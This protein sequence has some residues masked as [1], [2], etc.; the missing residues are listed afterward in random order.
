MIKHNRHH[1]PSLRALY[2]R[3][4]P[5]NL[6]CL[7]SGIMS[8]SAC[9]WLPGNRPTTPLMEVTLTNSGPHLARIRLLAQGRILADASLRPGAALPVPAPEPGGAWSTFSAQVNGGEARV[10][11]V[12]HDRPKRLTIHADPRRP[13]GVGIHLQDR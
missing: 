9:S 11:L 2:F 3:G 13:G 12:Q 1:P 7:I 6:F 10:V 4:T 8:L 5:L